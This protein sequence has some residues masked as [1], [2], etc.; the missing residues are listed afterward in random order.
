MIQIVETIN[1]GE[2]FYF[3]GDYDVPLRKGSVVEIHDIL[4][5]TY[6]KAQVIGILGVNNYKAVR[7][8]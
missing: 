5:D 4:Q 6:G 2:E 3:S 8:Q 1:I 7:I